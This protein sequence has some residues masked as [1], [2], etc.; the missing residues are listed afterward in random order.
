[1]SVPDSSRCVAKLCLSTQR[2]TPPGLLPFCRIPFPN[3]LQVYPAGHFTGRLDPWPLT[4]APAQKPANRD[5]VPLASL[6]RKTRPAQLDH[7]LF[8][9]HHPAVGI[10]SRTSTHFPTLVPSSSTYAFVG[11][12]LTSA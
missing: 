2:R 4:I 1:M 3:F 6:L 10:H 12:V 9:P 7:P 11:A 8:P 5:L